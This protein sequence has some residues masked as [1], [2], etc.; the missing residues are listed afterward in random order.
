MK[1]KKVLLTMM[2]AASLFLFGCGNQSDTDAD[3]QTPPVEA[4]TVDP[5]Q[6]DVTP[7]PADEAA[8]AEDTVADTSAQTAASEPVPTDSSARSSVTGII[9][10]ASAISVT[11]QTPDGELY[12]LSIPEEGV[13]GDL[14][15]I[16]VGQI[17]TFTYAGSLDEMHAYLVDISANGMVTGIYVEEYSFAIK[18]I[19]AV[20]N[21]DMKAIS[22][23]SNFPL[24]I[25]TGNYFGSMNT[26]GEFEAID[27]E[28]IFTEELVER[29]A[30]FNLFEL[31]YT[32]AGFCMGSGGPN[33][34]FDVDD[35]GILGI[36]G[37]NSTSTK[38]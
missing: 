6:P 11:I 26:S 13:T 38:R 16:T 10:E 19:D 35:D 31:E 37:I 2:I 23:L 4:T 28:K 7:D 24:F 15:A 21:M 18:I 5:A 25:D 1:I 22:D 20:R 17:A 3:T 27:N 14:S 33:I 29:I 34:T 30:N 12:A 8:A 32:E 9:V 36:I